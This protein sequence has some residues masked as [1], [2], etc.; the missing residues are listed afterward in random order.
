MEPHLGCGL[1]ATI[2]EKNN[3]PSQLSMFELLA[4][5][6]DGHE[7]LGITRATTL[8]HIMNACHELIA[9]QV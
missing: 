7:H 6:Q 4:H 8:P 1:I 3:Y 9:S 2:G 5:E